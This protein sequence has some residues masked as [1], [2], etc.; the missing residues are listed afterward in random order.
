MAELSFF[1]RVATHRTHVPDVLSCIAN[2]SNDEVFT[3]PDV[4]NKML[5]MLPQELFADPKTTFLDPATKT[6]VFLREIAKR[7]LEAQLPGYKERS[8]EISEKRKLDIPLDEYDI[9]FEKQ[10]QEKIDHI[11][12]NQL[13][14]IGITELTSLLARRSVYCSKYPNGPY[15][16][17]HFDDAE[18]NIRFRRT[19][20]KWKDGKCVF[21]GA[22]REE[23]DRGSEFE[24]HAYEFIHT[25]KPEE[26]FEMRFDVII[27]NPPYQLSTDKSSEKVGSAR[28]NVQAIPLYNRFV[29]Q[30]KKLNPRYLSMIIPARWFAGGMGLNDFRESM[31]N[32][33]HLLKLVDYPNSRDCFTGVDIAGGVCYFL[34]SHDYNGQCEVKNVI[35]PSISQSTR[36]IN[37]F[38]NLFIRSNVA[39]PIIHKVMSKEEQKLTEQV[40]SLDPFG[41]PTT[42]KGLEKPFENCVSLI[43][44]KGIGYVSRGEISKNAHL[45]D[46][47][48]VYIARVVPS[49]GEVGI[50][51]EKGYNAITQPRILKPNEICNFTYMLLGVFDTE[52]EAKNFQKYMALKFPRYMLRL[53]YSSMNISKNNFMFV[54]CLDFKRTWSDTELYKR[55]NLSEDEVAVIE[56]TIRQMNLDGGIE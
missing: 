8:V 2:L 50:D 14:G 10:L 49:N 40:F 6:G 16:I 13:F 41:F 33:N 48:K 23:Y 15:S 26:L 44:S 28:K 32:D 53:T 29:E 5:D 56:S 54:P 21:C 42:A 38:E 3:P 19:E 25:V 11:F 9:A 34:W 22:S 37:E 18:G 46:K 7:C 55:Y 39:I 51:P 43:H 36:D 45:V 52:G 30:A 4:V 35:G 27:G 17:T 31:M 20:H 12:H 1:D 24:S 47:W